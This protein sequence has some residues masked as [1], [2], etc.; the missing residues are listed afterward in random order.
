MATPNTMVI[1]PA[2]GKKESLLVVLA[3]AL[4]IGVTAVMVI[5]RPHDENTTPLFDWQISA[6]HNLRGPDQ[7]IYNALYSASADIYALQYDYGDWPDITNLEDDYLPP[8][9]R[10]LSWLRMG[11]VEWRFQDVVQSGEKQGLTLYHGSNAKFP[12]QGAWLLSIGHLHAG[13]TGMS[14]QVQIWRHP[15]TDA[16]MPESGRSNTLIINGWKEVRPYSGQTE[17]ERLQGSN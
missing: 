8:F 13:A 12:G 6:F 5:L 2:D 9:R 14:N 7:A 16:P 11:S 17:V 10:D 3:I 15:D 1:H 4:I